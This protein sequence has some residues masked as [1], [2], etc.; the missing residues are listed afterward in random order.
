MSRALQ[1][2][3]LSK[4]PNGLLDLL[5]HTPAASSTPSSLLARCCQQRN[6][7][8]ARLESDRDRT[9]EFR[10][11]LE[12]V[13]SRR[14][15][16]EFFQGWADEVDFS[17]REVIIEEAVENDRQ[18]VAPVE[19]RR[20]GLSES[21][22]REQNTAKAKQG[23]LFSMKYDKL[24]VSVGCYSQTFGTPGVKEHALF[25]KDVGDARKIRNRLLACEYT[26]PEMGITV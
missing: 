7:S 2:G 14:S 22:I 17:K 19:D 23:Q 20:Q 8:I 12:P 18:G 25:L 6:I 3:R 21:D 9:L 5:S 16:V 4:L 13:R 15:K 10:T 11:A 24:V 26:P 1:K